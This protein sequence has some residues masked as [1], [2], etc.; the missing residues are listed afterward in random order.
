[1]LFVLFFLKRRYLAV[2]I[3]FR[4]LHTTIDSRLLYLLMQITRYINSTNFQLSI[5]QNHILP[6]I[7][8]ISIIHLVSAYTAKIGIYY[9]TN[10]KMNE[11]IVVEKISILTTVFLFCQS[12]RVFK[13]IVFCP[14]RYVYRLRLIWT[15]QTIDIS[16]GFMSHVKLDGA[17]LCF[18]HKTEISS[19]LYSFL[20]TL[21]L[22]C[23]RLQSHEKRFTLTIFGVWRQL[24]Q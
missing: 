12:T 17:F 16:F 15:H 23:Q 10:C 11:A 8:T 6:Q 7:H 19:S 3:V 18:F 22:Q 2:F 1:M 20:F 9:F 4:T 24:Y 21:S 13:I 14:V 5:N